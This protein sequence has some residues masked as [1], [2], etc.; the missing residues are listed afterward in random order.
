[1][2][3]LFEESSSLF[4]RKTSPLSRF[5]KNSGVWVMIRLILSS[6]TNSLSVISSVLVFLLITVSGKNKTFNSR[7]SNSEMEPI[8]AVL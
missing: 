5:L 7:S 2:E 4:K 3:F 1:M 6:L 8:L